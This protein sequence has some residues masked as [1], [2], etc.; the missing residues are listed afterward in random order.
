VAPSSR[1]ARAEV[2]ASSVQQSKPAPYPSKV[3]SAFVRR[4]VVVVLVLGALTLLTISFRSPA[5]GALHDLQG[6]GSS[7]LR[8]FQIAATRVATPFRDAYD[9]VD[10]LTRA[11]S[12]NARLRKQVS[13]YKAA[14]LNAR[15]A[16]TQLP[17]LE[18]LLRY[19]QGPTFPKDFGA[20]NARVISWSSS[21]FAHQLTIA[22]G[23]SSGIQRNSPVLSGDGLVGRVVNV[24][25]DSAIVTLLTDAQSYV[26]ARDLQTGVRGIVHR[27]PGGTLILDDVKK[28]EVV[29][30]GDQLVT[31][32]TRNPRYPDLYPFGIPIGRVSSVDVTDT[33][34]FLQVQVQPFANLGSLD[35]VAVLVAAKHKR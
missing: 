32:G 25:P 10:S 29:Q 24:F 22:A 9:Y 19:E 3:R 11:K 20:V 33:A 28:Q 21:P 18:K 30:S 23:S 26:T 2:L 1:S 16:A 7:A 5:S 14:Y 17:A 6:I 15:A 31:D 8:P 12:E 13:A 4:T 34:T 27:G 35:S